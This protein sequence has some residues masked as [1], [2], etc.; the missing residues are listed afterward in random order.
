MKT[1]LF[2]LS[3]FFLAF[4]SCTSLRNSFKNTS[5]ETKDCDQRLS[6]DVVPVNYD[7]KFWAHPER[8]NFRGQVRIDLEIKAPQNHIILHAKDLVITSV[9]LE[10]Q[11]GLKMGSHKKL[12]KNDLA[13]FNFGSTIDKGHYKLT[14]DYQGVY[15]DDLSGLYRVK[16]KKEFY[17]FSQLEP[18][19]ARK[20]LPCFDEPRFKA[21][22]ETTV[23]SAKNLVV[24]SNSPEI[25]TR[26]VGENTLHVFAKT[27]P[28]PTYLLALAIGHFDVVEGPKLGAKH[29]IS[30]RGIS[31]KGK[32]HKLA[33]AMKETP[34]ILARLEEYFQIDYPF[35]KL[36]ILAV[37]DFNAGAMENV[38]AITFR[39]WYLL[40]DKNA[41]SNQQQ[42]FYEIM[43]HE[44]AHQWFGNLVTMPWW[45]DLWLNEAFA[46]WL[47]YKIVAQVR[48]DFLAE[49]KL[50]GRAHSA[51]IQDS[52]VSA[53]KIREPITSSHD[54][55]NAF[56]SITYSKGAALLN[57]LENYLGPK[58]FR[59]AVSSHISRF[60]HRH[61]RSKDFL[62]SLAEF[63]DAKLIK[64]ADSFLNQNGVPL[65]N[66]SYSCHKSGVDIKINQ[67]R[68]TPLG[69]KASSSR[70][71]N[72]PMC[73]GYESLG[74]VKKYCFM[75]DK[76]KTKIAL[77]TSH[78]P[79][80]V[81]PNYHGLGYYRFSL[82]P[83]HW[84]GLHNAQK[85][86]SEAD[87][88]SITDSMLAELGRER[89]DFAFV[90]SS[91]GAMTGIHSPQIT[92]NFINL[93]DLAH[94]HWVENNQQDVLLS[95]AKKNL[96]PVYEKLLVLRNPSLDQQNLKSEVAYFLAQKINDRDIRADLSTLG[97]SYLNTLMGT[98]ENLKDFDENLV[99][100]ALSIALAD[101]TNMQIDS[102]I[103]QLKRENDSVIRKNILTGLAHSRWG[104]AA[105][106]I[107]S[108]VFDRSLR[109]N[110]Q[111]EILMRHLENGHNQ[112]MTWNFLKA[113]LNRLRAAL[114]EAQLSRLPSL[115]QGLCSKESAVEV[116]KLLGPIVN[117]YEGGPRNLRES[118]ER[119]EICAAQKLTIFFENKLKEVKQTRNL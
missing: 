103:K 15:Q 86:L 39:E 118:V 18:L 64:S 13:L 9:Q 19:S 54:I 73:I 37:P 88:L 38:G 11:Q 70:T 116:A 23:I 76:Q 84:S 49:E 25:S 4:S 98:K 60:S 66:L 55:H 46:T 5:Q 105:Y 100:S 47:S 114:S 40:L 10:G 109:K 59:Q 81:M 29:N 7:L 57:M 110:E 30:F 28:M 21:T 34:A 24:I 78:C 26:H 41:S 44:L 3:A 17:V 71:W 83:E 87:R 45:D 48:P 50:L 31:V 106:H 75:L 115:A 101:Q 20:M 89:L 95:Y 65:I 96:R 112:P 74:E 111:F 8:E 117:H 1:K 52:L 99:T 91:V 72:I 67:E 16:D 104:D 107:R 33:F 85:L 80:F 69:S 36:D 14:I 43:A 77:K 51:M 108:L 35:A 93:L 94:T 113:N 102:I 97:N 61:A 12:T 62:N 6:Q 2:L 53:R 68:Y 119:I 79:A 90:A 63:S 32:G 82:S 56:D 27:P 22:F 58:N 92:K 42:N